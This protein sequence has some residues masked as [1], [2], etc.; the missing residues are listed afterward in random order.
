MSVFKIDKTKDFTVM[1]NYHLR[2]RNL[3]Y[4]AKGLLS[5][6]LSLP[7]DWDYSMNGLVAVSKENIKAIRSA[8]KELEENHYLIRNRIQEKNGEFN[9][10]YQIYEKPY[11][12]L[13]HTVEG[14]TQNDIQ[15]NTNIQNT[16]KQIDKEDIQK[17]SFFVPEEHNILTLELIKKGYTNE[18]DIQLF[19]Y[20]DL[21]EQ[22]LNENN[23]YIDL[24]RITHYVIKRVIERNFIDDD[25][26]NIKNK[27]GY[28]KESIN[29]NIKVMNLDLDDL[30]GT[31][32]DIER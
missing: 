16:N 17:S 23:S 1:S 11:D 19:F 5:F 8:L 21:F 20:D 28:F 15:I 30:W 4:K 31:G 6:M 27:Y 2:D 24:I 22:L 13:G 7:D 10:E 25:G 3:T 32:E 14:H 18:D 26:N 12:H 29:N 9:Y